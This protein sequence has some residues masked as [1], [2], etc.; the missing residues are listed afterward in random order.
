MRQAYKHR[1]QDFKRKIIK[2]L[3]DRRELLLEEE[4][5]LSMIK[6]TEYRQG[7]NSRYYNLS[8]GG[9]GH[10]SANQ[11]KYKTIKEKLSLTA[12]ANYE[13]DSTLKQRISE[14]TKA[15]M[16]RPEVRERYKQGLKT[17]QMPHDSLGYREK[18]RDTCLS[19]QL[20]KGMI[21]V[22]YPNET[23]CFQI[24]KDD[25]R[26]L[27]GEVTS[28][29]KG[30]KFALGRKHTEES[31]KK[32]S[33]IQKKIAE[34]RDYAKGKDHHGFTGHYHTPWGIFETNKQAREACPLGHIPEDIL[35]RWCKL[36]SDELFTN[37]GRPP[38]ILQPE[39]LGKTR[40]EVGFWF[41]PINT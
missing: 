19:K 11:Q 28:P 38:S 33:L 14:T 35:Y 32:M 29:T 27:N 41:E 7:T 23:K 22:R 37:R 25:P 15:A 36:Q 24:S 1:P 2:T 12:K 5:Y 16:T 20:N 40:R 21:T 39:W 18:V 6:D 9:T 30:K 3:F 8:K 26:W 10:W 31:K 17:R 13:K 34:N 4:R